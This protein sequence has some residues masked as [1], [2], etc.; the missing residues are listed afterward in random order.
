MVVLVVIRRLVAPHSRIW[1]S[2]LP[3]LLPTADCPPK[4]KEEHQQTETLPV[5]DKNTLH[6]THH[7][8]WVRLVNP[9]D[10][11]QCLRMTTAVNKDPC[12]HMAAFGFAQGKLCRVRSGIRTL[13]ATSPDL[14][15]AW[16]ETRSAPSTPNS[17]GDTF[18][19]KLQ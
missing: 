6:H 11:V 13:F 3:P 7:I 5:M 10:N 1:P 4:G 12:A 14:D 18:L 9:P 17:G 2:L 16:S 15:P 8:Q 19:C